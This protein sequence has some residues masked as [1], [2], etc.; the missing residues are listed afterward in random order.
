MN[1]S[2]ITTS[3]GTQKWLFLGTL[4]EFNKANA[5]LKDQ[6]QPEITE[7]ASAY[8]MP[9]SGAQASPAYGQFNDPI[10]R[11]IDYGQLDRPVVDRILLQWPTTYTQASRKSI[12]TIVS[13]SG[14]TR[15]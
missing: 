9:D 12:T 8:T 5:W 15:E 10:A 7:A 3:G 11:Q 13:G 6:D 4:D 1:V 14:T 2:K